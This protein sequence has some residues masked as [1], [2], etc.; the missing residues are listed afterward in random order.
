[1]VSNKFRFISSAA[2]IKTSHGEEDGNVRSL[3]GEA[4]YNQMD[5]EDDNNTTRQRGNY[6]WIP[7]SVDQLR[8]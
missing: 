3:N 2:I 6:M 8:D 7:G 5:D 1:M 4:G